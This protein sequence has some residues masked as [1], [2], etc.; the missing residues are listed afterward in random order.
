M[1]ARSCNRWSIGR[2]ISIT[3]SEFVLITLGIQ[4]AVHMRHIILSSVTCPA[5]Q[6][7]S[8]LSYTRHE[9]EE[10]KV[11]EYTM[12]VLIFSTTLCETFLILRRIERDIVN[13]IGVLI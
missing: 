13:Y 4:H 7:F 11:I 12:C 9:F 5:V 8:T 1:E 2:A 10:K 3:Y 6:Y